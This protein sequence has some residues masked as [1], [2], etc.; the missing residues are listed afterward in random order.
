MKFIS[1]DIISNFKTCFHLRLFSVRLALG[2]SSIL[3]FTF[4]TFSSDTIRSSLMSQ[5]IIMSTIIKG[6]E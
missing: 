5:K 4:H 2:D 1:E 6:N 3:T